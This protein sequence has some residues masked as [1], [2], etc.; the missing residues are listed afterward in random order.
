[1]ME[2]YNANIDVGNGHVRWLAGEI[3][4]AYGTTSRKGSGSL[5]DESAA[6]GKGVYHY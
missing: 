3:E 5:P 1:M 2:E 4:P 6:H